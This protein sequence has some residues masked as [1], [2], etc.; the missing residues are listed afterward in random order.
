MKLRARL[1]VYIL[2]GFSLACGVIYAFAEVAPTMRITNLWPLSVIESLSGGR[3][4]NH[5]AAP[6]FTRAL[7]PESERRTIR[8]LITSVTEKT[9]GEITTVDFLPPIGR[10]TRTP[11]ERSFNIFPIV[12]HREWTAEDGMRR[13]FTSFYPVYHRKEDGP[14]HHMALFPIYMSG[15]AGNVSYPIPFK[16]TRDYS[17]VFPIYGNLYGAFGNDRVSFAF[18]PLYTRIEKGGFVKHQFL[19]PIFTVGSGGGYRTVKLWPIYGQTVKEGQYV[20]RFLAWPVFNFTKNLSAD[21]A[22]GKG[23]VAG[24]P[25]YWDILEGRRHAQSLFPFYG[26]RV[27]PDLERSFKMWPLYINTTYIKEQFE[28]RDYLW[29]VFSRTTGSQTGFKVWPIA[30]FRKKTQV[31]PAGAVSE[32]ISSFYLWTLGKY[33]RSTRPDSRRL[34]HRFFPLWVYGRHE[35]R[36][37][38]R[39]RQVFVWPIVSFQE[40]SLTG[41]KAVSFPNL[42]GAFEA[43]F[44][45]IQEV[46]SPLWRVV[47]YARQGEESRL[48]L[49]WNLVDWRKDGEEVALTIGPVFTLHRDASGV[50]KYTVLS[51]IHILNRG[52]L[53]K[54]SSSGTVLSSIQH[55][56]R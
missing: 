45:A 15:T 13:K 2:A 32:D 38:Y 26:K 56:A 30:G 54:E 4:Y 41:V 37:G 44:P 52:T 19:W 31:S 39:Q 28:T 18:W 21:T 47:D 34:Y 6:L 23:I 35:D 14:Q 48:S 24:L 50:Q 43:Q 27:T 12:T 16:S 51:A 7:R 11:T 49:L 40:D 55:P 33:E 22:L 8:P 5:A 25:V 29:P 3:Q 1:A 20:S 10:A 17:A 42:L 36:H 9:D 46:Y 53:P